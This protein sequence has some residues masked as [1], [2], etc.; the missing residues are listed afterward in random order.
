MPILIGGNNVVPG[1]VQSGTG[2]I[3]K[4]ERE[5]RN[6]ILGPGGEINKHLG[7]NVVPGSVQ[8]G[9]EGGNVKAG[10]F[11][12]WM[13]FGLPATQG[14]NVN[15]SEGPIDSDLTTDGQ[16]AGSKNGSVSY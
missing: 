12:E 1:S 10:S 14:N 7:A 8:S 11:E 9:T 5:E 4:L 13:N 3:K 6:E 15:L 2:A 16:P